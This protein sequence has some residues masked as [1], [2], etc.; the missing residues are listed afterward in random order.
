MFFADFEKNPA[1][2]LGCNGPRIARERER[3]VVVVVVVVIV[4]VKVGR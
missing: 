2:T 3:V 1:C 4:A